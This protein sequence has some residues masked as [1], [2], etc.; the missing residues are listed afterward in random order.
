MPLLSRLY[1]R[2]ALICLAVGNTLGALILS[3][4]AGFGDPRLWLLLPVHLCL[5]AL[6]WLVQLSVG[7][8]YWIAPRIRNFDRG[9]PRWAWSAFAC[10]QMG[11]ACAFIAL[12]LVFIPGIQPD[13]RGWAFGS[14]T[15]QG[16]G[17]LL[18]FIH[19]LPRIRPALAVPVNGAGR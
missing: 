7:V 6:G 14:V 9:R 13:L 4:K 10:Q 16:A 11:V 15:L 3:V 17:V 2:S 8:A 1:I 18:F 19:L 5:L 12:I